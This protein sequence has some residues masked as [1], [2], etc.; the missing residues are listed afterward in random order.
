MNEFDSKND[1]SFILERAKE[2]ERESKAA[3]DMIDHRLDPRQENEIVV[4]EKDFI[5][6]K[7]MSLTKRYV[8]IYLCSIVVAIQYAWYVKAIGDGKSHRAIMSDIT[9]P[10]MIALYTHF[11]IEMKTLQGRLK[12]AF[13]SGL[14]YATGSIIIV[15]LLNKYLS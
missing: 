6:S 8:I 4:E 14:G 11:F 2:R 7:N 1:Y 9:M 13:V 10:L 5:D 3:A 12:M 15:G